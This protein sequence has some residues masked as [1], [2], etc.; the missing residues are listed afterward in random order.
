MEVTPMSSE[1]LGLLERE[2]LAERA[3][4]NARN[5]LDLFQH[6]LEAHDEAGLSASAEILAEILTG[7]PSP[8]LEVARTRPRR[9]WSSGST[10]VR[11][12]RS[13]LL[14]PTVEREVADVRYN[15]APSSV[16]A[17]SPEAAERLLRA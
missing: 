7:R 1:W 11:H 17:T 14:N 5:Y 16:Y 6:A 13:L 8:L 3:L 10:A 9:G 2:R 4:S 15:A 12:G